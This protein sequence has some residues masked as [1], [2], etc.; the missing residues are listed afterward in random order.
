M[1]E[2]QKNNTTKNSGMG[3]AI[4]MGA[5]LGIV[6]GEFVFDDVGVGLVIGAGIGVVFGGLNKPKKN[7]NDENQ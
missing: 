7:G 3:L 1:T 6:F 2:E 4:A 5:G